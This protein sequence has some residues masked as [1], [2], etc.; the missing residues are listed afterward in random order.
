MHL[1]H[2][3]SARTA[4]RIQRLAA[5]LPTRYVFQRELGEGGA[6][7]VLLA[8]DSERGELV[9]VKILRPEVATDIGEKRFQREIEIVRQFKHP[10][11]LPLLDYG[12]IS[13]QAFFTTPFIE[14]DTLKA[15]IKR[16]RQ[17]PLADVLVIMGDVAAALD[18][19]HARG[20]IHRDIKPANILLRNT[21]TLVA[22]FG[23]AR[24][25]AVDRADAIT[26]SGISL[27][28]AEYM[29]PEQGGAMRELDARCDV[30]SLGC[31]IY[32]MLA[33]QPPFTGKS[34]QSIIARQFEETPRP[35][36]EM[37]PTVPD[38]VD[39]AIAKS[40]AK[41]RAHR[42]YSAGE[43]FDAVDAGARS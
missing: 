43:F 1:N 4:T 10:N 13:G 38:A 5:A 29:S 2:E 30:Y 17:L 6:A 24:A 19:A 26:R 16:E 37:C 39:R 35:V 18:H 27:G 34:E 31:V 20:I 14:G 11:I 40:L 41:V 7:Y 3:K 33:G 25:M 42:Y 23:I 32:E 28:T 21:G 12:T 22:D 8:H 9:A 15:R 36:R